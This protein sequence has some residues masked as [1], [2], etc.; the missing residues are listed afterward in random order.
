MTNIYTVKEATACVIT[1]RAQRAS[2]GGAFHSTVSQGLKHAGLGGV[3]TQ[4]ASIHT[5]QLRRKVL[6][7]WV[8]HAQVTHTDPAASDL[9]DL[10][11]HTG[12]PT[13]KE[14]QHT[15][16]VVLPVFSITPVSLC[17]ISLWSI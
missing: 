1:V 7:A 11:G 14:Q 4:M 3:K 5:P 2:A 15:D 6:I 9:H 16:T 12:S 17:C 8:S 13:V 10:R